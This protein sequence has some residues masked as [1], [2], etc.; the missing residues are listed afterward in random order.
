MDARGDDIKATAEDL[1]NAA[2]RLQAIEEAK[3]ELTSD[4]PRLVTL[5]A[6]AADLAAEI[7][8]KTRVEYAIATDPDG[9]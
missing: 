5:S 9:D 8:Q 3:L 4:D 6:E 1:A 7:A 2:E